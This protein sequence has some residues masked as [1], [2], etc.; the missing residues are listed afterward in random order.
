MVLS[1][2]KPHVGELIRDVLHRM[3]LIRQPVLQDLDFRL[4][5]ATSESWELSAAF[6]WRTGPRFS[7]NSQ[8][9]AAQ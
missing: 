2:R 7:T 9:E 4:D 6:D 5:A 3:S 8:A 1:L